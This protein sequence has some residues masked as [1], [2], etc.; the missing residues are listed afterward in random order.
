MQIT[1]KLEVCR[2]NQ[3]QIRNQRPRLNRNT[4]FLG[5]KA[6][7]LLTSANIVSSIYYFNAI[8]CFIHLQKDLEDDRIERE[9]EKLKLQLK[10]NKEFIDQLT[11]ELNSFDK[12]HVAHQPNEGSQVV[13]TEPSPQDAKPPGLAGLAGLLLKRAFSKNAP[14]PSSYLSIPCQSQPPI[15]ERNSKQFINIPEVVDQLPFDNPDG[16]GWKQGWDVKYSESSWNSSNQLHVY[17]VCH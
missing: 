10:R 9:V 5:R 7:G 11:N 13:Q 8:I 12:N 6:G 1:S 17:A 2:A 15:P 14:D 16:G 4:L 3:D